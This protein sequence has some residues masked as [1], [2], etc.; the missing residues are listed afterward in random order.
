MH[1][2]P[3]PW[4][5]GFSKLDPCYHCTHDIAT[6]CLTLRALLQL[7]LTSGA[8]PGCKLSSP[9]RIQMPSGTFDW[10]KSTAHRYALQVMRRS[11]TRG[12]TAAVQF[13]RHVPSQSSGQKRV[14]QRRGGAWGLGMWASCIFSLL[15]CPK[16]GSRRSLRHVGR[17]P[18]YQTAL[19]CQFCPLHVLSCL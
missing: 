2:I 7:F 9:R 6:S 8:Q 12:N 17:L 18:I 10:H 13:G 1:F 4:F 5:L 14:K 11:C 3:V 16:D 19:L 15:F